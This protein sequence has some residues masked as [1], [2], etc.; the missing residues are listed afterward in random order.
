MARLDSP[1]FAERERAEQELTRNG[2]AVPVGWVREA[3]AK[4]ASEEVQTRLRRVLAR[5][6]KPGPARWRLERAAQVLALA[7]TPETRSVLREWASGPAGAVATG[8]AAAA[9]TRLRPRP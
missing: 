1:R 6:E 8:E 3:L 7:D 2:I 9:L 4:Q 5:V